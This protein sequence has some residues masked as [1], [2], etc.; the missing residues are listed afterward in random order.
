MATSQTLPHS[1]T[2]PEATSSDNIANTVKRMGITYWHQLTAAG[3]PQDDAV[4]IA[5]AI[6]KFDAI[7]RIPSLEQ[8]ALIEQFS[9]LI[10]RARLWRSCLLLQ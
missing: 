3:I 1:P 5:A 6:A 10:C 2:T 8:K 4:K 7:R 9:P